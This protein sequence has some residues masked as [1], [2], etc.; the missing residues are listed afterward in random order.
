MQEAITQR[1][2][3][4]DLTDLLI[5]VDT[6]TNFTRHLELVNGTADRR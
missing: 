1:L 5:E 4:V 3:R 2:P 6:W